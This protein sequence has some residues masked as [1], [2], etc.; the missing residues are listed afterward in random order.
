MYPL[1]YFLGLSSGVILGAF[2]LLLLQLWQGERI[3]RVRRL[4]YI[5]RG[6]RCRLV[7]ER[8][9]AVR[10]ARIRLGHDT[11]GSWGMGPHGRTFLDDLFNGDDN[12]P[13]KK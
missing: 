7:A 13:W 8:A 11:P 1:A 5:A 2:A 4:A 6:K 12:E 3:E 10:A 9:L